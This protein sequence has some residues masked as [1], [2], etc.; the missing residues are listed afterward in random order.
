METIGRP[1]AL[2]SRDTST[3]LCTHIRIKA[4]N[5]TCRSASAIESVAS[6]YISNGYS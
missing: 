6:R 2:G 1:W 4:Y 5:L 3:M